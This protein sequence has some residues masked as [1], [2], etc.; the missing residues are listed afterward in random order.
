MSTPRILVTAPAGQV[1]W[2]LRRTLAPLG[3]VVAA[4]RSGPLALDLADP[5]RIRAVVREVRPDLV[6]NAA[7]Y[8]A[9]DK[10]EE[11]RDLA[12]AVNATAP[13]ILAEEAARLGAPLIHYST[14]YVFDGTK[15]TPYVEDDAPNPVN[16][17]GESKLAGERAVQEAGGAAVILRTSWV[18]G[19]RGRNFLLTMRRLAAE[20]AQLNIVDDQIA[21]PTWSRM[22]AETTAAAVARAGV[23]GLQERAGLYHLAAA[24]ETSWCGFA[25]RIFE[26]MAE[27]EGATVPAVQGLPTAD[28]P[29]PAQR[30]LYTKLD[31]SRLERTWGVYLPEWEDALALCLGN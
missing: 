28:Y 13:G 23:G 31:C 25:R 3:E 10:A 21:S 14:D 30:P 19:L 29:T 4:G 16:V 5:D 18:Y 20:K 12:M 6:V 9:V 17:Y 7:A 26:L 15:G 11:E 22:I 24:G 1:G 2:E 8:T 27:R